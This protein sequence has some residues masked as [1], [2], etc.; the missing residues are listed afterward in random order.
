MK[1][2]IVN[3]PDKDE[4]LI[5]GL[6]KKLHLKTTIVNDDEREEDAIAKWIDEAASSGEVTQ[7]TIMKTL[8]KNGLKI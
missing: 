7:E 8:K 1:T 6:L 3:I 2:V 5:I 4:S